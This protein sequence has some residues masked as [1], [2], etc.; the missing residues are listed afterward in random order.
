M[1]FPSLLNLLESSFGGH[2]LA[3]IFLIYGE[4][5]WMIW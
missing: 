3:K 1:P 5:E 2:T 4:F